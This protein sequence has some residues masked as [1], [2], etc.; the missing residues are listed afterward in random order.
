LKKALR[1]NAFEVPGD[2][3]EPTAEVADS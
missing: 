2:A 1:L 3:P